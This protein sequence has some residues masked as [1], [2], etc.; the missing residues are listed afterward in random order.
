MIR[1][2]EDFVFYWRILKD[3]KEL[4]GVMIVND[5]SWVGVGW[6][7]SSLTP[8]CRAFPEIHGKNYVQAEPLPHPE[9][10]SQVTLAKNNSR[11][12]NSA[13]PKPEPTHGALTGEQTAEPSSKSA[14]KRRSPKSPRSELSVTS[15]TNNNDVTVQTSV[16][17]QVSTQQG[18]KKRSPEFG[19]PAPTAG[20]YINIIFILVNILMQYQVLY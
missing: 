6:R 1:F 13:E 19:T 7:P 10:K 2:S 18:R 17:Y 16:T 5:T 20:M 15:R 12:D 9:P 11:S 14:A 8:S 3:S 4:E